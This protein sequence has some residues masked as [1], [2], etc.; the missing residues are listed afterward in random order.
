[1]IADLFEEHR[2]IV[3]EADAFLAL[4]QRVPPASIEEI[5]RHR[6]RL[7]SLTMTHVRTE[8]DMII[9]PLLASGRLEE[10]TG[11]VALLAEMREGRR[12]YSDQIRN[13]TPQAIEANR[14]DYMDAVQLIVENLKAR[15]VREEALLYWP[16][17]KLLAS[18][19][20]LAATD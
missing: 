6:A 11:A 12:A 8:E 16:A 13:W 17:L 15:I 18:D 10:L 20:P 5:N 14:D 1:M 2:V 9:Q 7:G 3:E 19:P 4:V